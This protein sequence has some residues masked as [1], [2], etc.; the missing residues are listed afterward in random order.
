MNIKV[1]LVISGCL[2][3]IAA[4][5]VIYRQKYILGSYRNEMHVLIE[6]ARLV[7]QDLE[8]MMNS[9]VDL[10][11]TVV[12]DIHDQV[13]PD[14]EEQETEEE[15][16]S[17]DNVLPAGTLTDPILSFYQYLCGPQYPVAAPATNDDTSAIPVAPDN[18]PPFEEL[19][20]EDEPDYHSMHPYLAV[21]FMQEKGFTIKEIA[22]KLG[23]GQGEIHLMLN[24]ER[25]KKSV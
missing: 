21:R 19:S 3:A 20:A 5:A 17:V 8:E 14:P 24:L 11:R 22:Q 23:R 9:A 18:Q 10:G 4:L 25:K 13:Q 15:V 12:S 1:L 16:P 7:S 2:L 6:E